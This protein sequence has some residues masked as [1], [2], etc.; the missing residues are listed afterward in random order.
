MNRESR[1]RRQREEASRPR[2]LQVAWNN[3]GRSREA[4]LTLL[5]GCNDAGIDI[6]QVQEPWWFKG[7]RTQT[8]PG[9][10]L[11]A[12][13]DS[14]DDIQTRP[15]VLTYV[16]KG[17]NLQVQ[18]RRPV[19]SRDLLWID[20]NGI[21][22]LNCY[23]QP[24]TDEVVDY[25]TSLIPPERFVAGGDLNAHDSYWEPGVESSGRGREL[26][27]WSLTS[28]ATYIG[29]IGE[30][31]H[32]QGHVLD[33]T[34]SNIPFA[35]TERRRRL[36]TSSDHE[37]LVTTIPGRGL[38]QLEQHHYR[39]KDDD[40]HTF[41]GL[42]STGID[43]LPD[44]SAINNTDE[45]D[46]AAEAFAQMWEGCLKV[47]GTPTRA[48]PRAAPWWTD[49]CKEAWKIWKRSEHP[50]LIRRGQE[51]W[52][53][54]RREFLRTVRAAKREYWR[55]ILAEAKDGPELYRIIAW[56]KLG[57]TL[58][59]PP[60][61]VEGREITDTLEKVEALEGLILKRYTDEDDIDGDPLDGWS[62]D[63][64]TPGLEWNPTATL[65][66]VEKHTIGVSSTTAG[67]DGTTVRLMSWC[68]SSIK[69]WVHSFAV[70][71]L[72]LAHIPAP[73]KNA[74][75]SMIPKVGKRDGSSY[76][77]YRPIALLSCW[78]KGLE[79]LLAKRMA[80]QALASGII[81]PQ[82][83]SALPKRSAMDL[84]SSLTHDIEWALSR[85]QVVSF[86]TADAQGAFDALLK[87]RHLK[88]M[89][90]QGWDL[91]WLR[92]VQSFLTGRRVRT[93][94]E[95]KTTEFTDVPCGTPQGSPL[96]PVLYLLYLL[97]LL[98][99]DRNLR[100]GYADDLGFYRVGKTLDVT[101]EA[102][103]ADMRLVMEWSTE[104]K[105]FF[106]PEKCEAMHFARKEGHYNPDIL[107]NDELTITPI[108]ADLGTTPGANRKKLQPAIRWLGMWFDRKLTFRRHVQERCIRAMALS[109]HIRSL[110]NTKY[111]PPPDALRKAITA[112]VLPMAL[113]GA[114][115]WYGG[116]TKPGKDGREVRAKVGWHI[117]QVQRVINWAI[118]GALPVWRTTP[119]GTL[120]RDAGV[121]TA[122]LALE[123]ARLRLALRLR[124]ADETHPLVRRMEVPTAT[125]GRSA[126]ER[127]RAATKL[128]RAATLLPATDRT[129]IEVPSYPE[130]SRTHPTGEPRR[131]KK[132]A[133]DEFRDWE[134]WLTDREVVIHSDGSKK[135]GET[136]YGY[137]IYRNGARRSAGRASLD[138]LSEVFD[139]EATGAWRGLERAL[140]TIGRR[141]E[142]LTYW[143]CLD[144]TATI[145]GLR[146]KSPTTSQ[147]A[148][149][150]FH[151][152][153]KQHDVRVKWCPG[154]MG[155]L[156]NEAA[157]EQAKKGTEAGRDANARPTAAGIKRLMRHRL[158][159]FR[160]KHWKDLEN[161]LSTH[162]KQWRLDYDLDCPQELFL[163]REE[164]HRYLA[165]RS[166][167]GD[168]AWYHRKFEHDEAGLLCSC[169]RSKTP[170]HLVYCRKALRMFSLWPWP[171]KDRPKN[172][173][174]TNTEK[175]D[176]LR[177]LMRHPEAFKSFLDTT[178]FYHDICPRSTRQAED[179]GEE[180]S[181]GERGLE[182]EGG[183]ME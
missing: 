160:G 8:H 172:Y 142:G 3:V 163:G 119:N 71:C 63:E 87:N 20:V 38:E 171:S 118:R 9:Y 178:K 76:R 12:P 98:N 84:V 144:N 78:G 56:H 180:G 89:R 53:E 46:R 179:E 123:E 125:R 23:R 17:G 21:T 103:A 70:K 147:W 148:F 74:E 55:K 60:L 65:E 73:W 113:Y 30:A 49:E 176:Y 24:S 136:G 82:Q 138:E 80:W 97:E 62:P 54:E 47:A 153:A 77:A 90:E 26:V 129:E 111:G 44:P 32:N 115:A 37:T 165:V 28:G 155:I 7:T 1:R 79:R 14:W 166:G 137:V 86:A 114:E 31:T 110:A 121:S 131:S 141:E 75:V 154:H 18:Q 104:N 100:F 134:V 169:G 19:D 168:F 174:H 85:G 161:G 146:G 22:L 93:R 68:W 135:N 25:L 108:S 173:P 117:D 10:E 145:W 133:A 116:R 16:R 167:H 130:G 152:A 99:K 124:T 33:L 61:V 36:R 83:A 27:T 183:V 157:D 4:H 126:G 40:M 105:V 127:L 72:V 50:G 15:R 150:E 57:T 151:K 29:E 159:A 58:K 39:V 41:I 43:Q 106:A 102:L 6:I 51:R 107:V 95:G 42:V 181:E 11:Y 2:N 5:S 66:E 13:V 156:G 34:F 149:R 128:Q 91:G 140:K 52:T 162:Y 92:I 175:R 158:R 96:S 48:S 94:L 88:R 182:D 112:C 64:L 81:S 143:V 45:I 132:E 59:S 122:E 139:A 164:L 67:V 120:C 177:D 101:S 69:H 170:E 109:R 35:S